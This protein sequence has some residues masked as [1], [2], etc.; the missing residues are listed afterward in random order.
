MKKYLLLMAVFLFVGLTAHATVKVTFT[1]DMSVWAK[2]GYFNPAT[3]TVRV[4]GD[5]NSWSTTA[6]DLAKGAGADSLKYSA[7]ISGVASGAINYKFI[8]INSAGVQWESIDN[9]TATIGASDT[10]LPVKYFNNISGKTNH[11]WF[12]IDMSLPIKQGKLAVATDSVGVTG[13]FTGW[14]TSSG[15]YLKLTKGANDSVY[16]GIDDTLASGRTLTFKFI[17]W[18]AGSVNWED[19][20]NRTYLVPEQDSSVFFD[21]WNRVNPNIP[22]GSGK[23]NFNV[24]MSVM[25]RAGIFNTAKDSVLMSAGFN[26]WTTSDPNAYLSQNPINDSLFFF[27][28]NF[29]NEPYGD[30][31]YKYVVKL[32][33]T[34]NDVD[35]LWKDGYERPVHW[36]GGNRETYFHGVASQDTTDYYDNIQPDWFI[37]SGTNLQVKFSVDMTPAMDPAKQ[38]VPFNPTTD[39]LY[40]ICEEPAFTRTQ[41]WIDADTMKVLQMTQVGST[42]IWSGTLNVKDPAFN[43]F[44][45]R[46]AIK[47]SDGS[48]YNEPAGFD[49]FAYRVRYVGQDVA[50]HFPK[51]PWTMPTD[52]WTNNNLKT[53]Q[54]VDPYTSLTEVKTIS[55]NPVTYS[56][57]QNY[58]NPFNPSTTINFSIQKRGLVTL[59]VYNIIG[60]VVAT[61]VN[62]EMNTGSYS[63]SFDASRF[64][65]GV[66]FYAIKA[67]NFSQVK[68]MMLLK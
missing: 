58:P 10:T 39:K 42:N 55:Q 52:T 33:T 49:A 46:Y 11:V 13:D 41:G 48:W 32:H 5:F 53:D 26:G 40:W 17:Y 43:A 22:T 56:L 31:P 9:R 18:S 2:N 1:V 29:T 15:G 19:D 50:S 28:Q 14:G 23:I 67:G 54:E 36:G 45:Y 51:N 24:D 57:S 61:L 68:K 4:A 34:G 62:Q 37:P 21:Y 16:S 7:Q 44:E 6:N 35:T 63:Y 27:T 12:K 47:Y 65:S 64:S 59:K 25:A 60:Q 66:Y 8:F 20:P 30:K 3:D 38:A